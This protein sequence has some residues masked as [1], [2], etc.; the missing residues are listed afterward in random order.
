MTGTARR[1]TTLSTRSRVTWASAAGL[2]MALWDDTAI[3]DYKLAK[4]KAAFERI[5]GAELRF[6][7]HAPEEVAEAGSPSDRVLAGVPQMEFLNMLSWYGT[8]AGAHLG[9][10]PIAPMVGQRLTACTRWSATSSRTSSTSTT[11]RRQW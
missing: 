6:T 8:H 4:I 5:P 2:H 7:R 9:N 11:L 1:R 10:G 3:A